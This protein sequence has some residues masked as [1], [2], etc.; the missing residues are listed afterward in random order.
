MDMDRVMEIYDE[1]EFEQNASAILPVQ[2]EV[3]RVG[4]R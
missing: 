4:L 1:E 2:G 3:K